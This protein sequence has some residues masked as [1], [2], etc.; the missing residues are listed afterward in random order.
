MDD[1]K[2][3]MSFKHSGTDEHMNQRSCGSITEPVHVQANGALVLK[4]GSGH[5]LPSPTKKPS[6]VEICL[7]WIKINFL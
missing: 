4:V 3:T 5:K 6:P 7:Y 2:E 1:T